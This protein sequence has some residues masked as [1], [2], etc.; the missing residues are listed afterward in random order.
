[1]RIYGRTVCFV[2]CH[3]AAHLEGVIRRNEDFEYIYRSMTFTS[4]GP[5]F[6][7]IIIFFSFQFCFHF[8]LCILQ[9]CHRERSFLHILLFL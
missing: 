9:A 6:T 4:A 3:L 7:L 5:Q 8:F 2:N 1:M